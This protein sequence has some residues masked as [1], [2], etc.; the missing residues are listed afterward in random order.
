[1]QG[2]TMNVIFIQQSAGRGGSKNSLAESLAAIS[3]EGSI[4]P[5][6]ICSETGPFTE[7][8]ARI[9]VPLTI[10]PLPAWRKLF[11]RIRFPSAMRSIS[12][13]LAPWRPDWIISNEMWWA[14]HASAIARHLGCRSAVILRDGIATVRKSLQYRLQEHDLILPVS[15]TIASALTSHPEFTSKVQVLFNSVSVPAVDAGDTRKLD[16]L[17][18]PYPEVRRWLLVVGKLSPRKNQAAAVQVLRSLIDAGETDAGLLLAGDIDPAYLPVMEQAIT[19]ARLGDRVAMI[20]NF[21]GVASLLER[22]GTLLLPSFREGLPRSLV[23]AVTAGKPAFSYPCEGVDD[24]YGPHRDTFVSADPT[25][26]AL[27]STIQRAWSQPE[28]SAKAFAEVRESVLSRFS[29]Q[30]HLAR[31]SSLLNEPSQKPSR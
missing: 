15:S 7:R 8:C 19:G 13:D 14:P 30:A 28:A 20:G 9:G 29:P 3:A 25:P 4:R 2:H 22:A 1:M 17:L 10:A 27:V 16:Q 31:L 5:R 6:V 26:A 18:L 12:R 21:D 11:E 24:I 23:E